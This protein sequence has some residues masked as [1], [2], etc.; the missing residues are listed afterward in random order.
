M[1]TM[2][3]CCCKKKIKIVNKLPREEQFDCIKPSGKIIL[4]YDEQFEVPRF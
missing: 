4:S 1:F 2:G 3:S